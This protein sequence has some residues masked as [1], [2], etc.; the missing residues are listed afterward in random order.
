MGICHIVGAG[1]GEISFLPEKGDLIIAADGGYDSLMSAGIKPDWAVGDFDSISGSKAPETENV[2]VFPSE[3][4]YTDSALAAQLGEREGYKYFIFHCCTGGDLD[5]TLAN[6][7][8]MYSMVKRGLRAVMRDG[9]NCLCA[10][11]NGKIEFTERAHGKISIF[12]LSESSERVNLRGL[13]Y[14]L[15][16]YRMTSD[17]ALGVRNEFTGIAASVSVGEGALLLHTAFENILSFSDY[18]TDCRV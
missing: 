5:H 13:K 4:D 2:V 14:G 15:Q 1:P 16:N 7:S 8:E 10:V 9:N 12:S 18:F 3:K 6:I 11:K 17:Y